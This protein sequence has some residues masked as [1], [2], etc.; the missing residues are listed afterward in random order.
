M[1][2]R[3][4]RGVR[5][6]GC[7]R[8]WSLRC[9][10]G[11]LAARW[12]LA[13]EALV[14]QQVTRGRARLPAGLRRP[15]ARSRRRARCSR[16]ARLAAQVRLDRQPEAA[17]PFGM[18]GVALEPGHP[19]VTRASPADRLLEALDRICTILPWANSGPPRRQGSCGCPRA[20]WY[21][22]AV[23]AVRFPMVPLRPSACICLVNRPLTSL[24]NH[25]G[26]AGQISVC[27][28]I[29]P[30]SCSR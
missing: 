25:G 5:A 1:G 3:E 6:A 9:G 11:R 26:F 15:H 12:S 4:Q 17:E 21:E 13:V 27:L 18:R 23:S 19:I 10:F 24:G 2:G 30:T 29:G 20:G 22:A 28:P 14:R 7:G 8:R 16:P